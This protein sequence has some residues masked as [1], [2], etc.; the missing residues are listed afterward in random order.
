M[1]A[2]RSKATASSRWRGAHPAFL[3]REAGR[4]SR[5]LRRQRVPRMATRLPTRAGCRE[6][7]LAERDLVAC[8]FATPIWVCLRAVDERT[9]AS[10]WPSAR[11]LH[12]RL[13]HRDWGAAHAYRR[14][15]LPVEVPVGYQSDRA[16]GR[17]PGRLSRHEDGPAAV[18]GDHSCSSV[19]RGPS[20][21]TG[22]RA[23]ACTRRA[24]RTTARREISREEAANPNAE[25][26]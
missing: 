19:Q 8:T 11:W 23:G 22:A 4:V 5:R 14:T 24:D 18:G 3:R 16:A 10:E 25:R 20:C 2:G 26:D 13:A 1:S 17:C 21:P 12:A 9:L 6:R 15:A 7:H